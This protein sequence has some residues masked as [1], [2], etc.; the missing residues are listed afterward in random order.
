M[1]TSPEKAVL[2]RARVPAKRLRNAERILGQLGLKTSDAINM[3]MAQVELRQGLPF[4]MTV[5]GARML[6]AETQAAEW[7]EALGAY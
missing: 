4:D 7:A 3:L 2:V 6:P 1:K 5:T